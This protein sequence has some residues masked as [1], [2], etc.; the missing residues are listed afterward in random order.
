MGVEPLT[1]QVLDFQ[2]RVGINVRAAPVTVTIL[3][4]QNFTYFAGFPADG[5][6]MPTMWGVSGDA[7]RVEVDVP[8]VT[9]TAG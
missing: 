6:V 3:G 7:L 5:I 9:Q 4:I 8:C 1:G 2:F